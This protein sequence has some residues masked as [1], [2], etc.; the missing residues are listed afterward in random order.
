VEIVFSKLQEAILNP[1]TIQDGPRLLDGGGVA[2]GKPAGS[3]RVEHRK[4]LGKP[5]SLGLD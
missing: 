2:V 4:L 1:P 5:W 3:A